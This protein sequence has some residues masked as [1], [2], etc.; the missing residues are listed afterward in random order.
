MHTNLTVS[1]KKDDSSLD[2]KYAAAEA[3]LERARQSLKSGKLTD[4]HRRYLNTLLTGIV[5]TEQ[6]MCW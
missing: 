2:E 1:P 6:V 3:T 4:E 5:V